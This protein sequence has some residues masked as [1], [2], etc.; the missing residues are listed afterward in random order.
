MSQGPRTIVDKVGWIVVALSAAY[1]VLTIGEPLRMNWGDPWTDCNALITGHFF[2]K[3]GFVKLAFTPI[4]DIEP[5]T[6]DSLRYTHYPPL[7]DIINGVQQRIHGAADLPVFRAPAIALSLYALLLFYRYV[8]LLWG[9]TE[10]TLTV[11]FFAGN[12]LWLQ[13]ADTI[14]HIPLYWAT[15]F[16]AML[17]SARWLRDHKTKDVVLAGVLTFAC[18]L[19]SYDFIFFVPVMIGATPLLLGQSLWTRETRRLFAA[20]AVGAAASIVLKYVL[21]IWAVGWPQ[22][23]GDLVFQF[24]ERATTKHGGDYKSGFSTILMF[25][26]WRFFTPIFFVVLALQVVLLAMRAFARPRAK[27]LAQAK[28]SASPLLLLVAGAPFI[29]VFSQLFCEQYHPTL[30]LLPYY[31]LSAAVLVTRCWESSRRELRAAAVGLLVLGFGWQV[32]ELAI[33]EKT[34]LLRSDIARVRSVLEEHDHHRFVLSNGVTIAPALYYWNRYQLGVSYMPPEAIPR[35]VV[36]LQDEFGDEPIR[37]LHF[38]DIEKSVIDKYLYGIFVGQR[39]WDWIAD[40]AGHVREWQPG[41][42]A[43]DEALVAYI[44]QF[45][46][47]EL[48]TGTMRVYRMDRKTIDDFLSKKIMATPTTSIDFGDKSSE[49]F[50]VYGVRYPEKYGEG[51]GFAWLQRR[52]PGRYKFTLQGL[53]SVP[54]GTPRDDAALRLAMPPGKSYRIEISAVTAVPDQILTATVNGSRE[55]ARAPIPMGDPSTVVIDV[56]A[57]LLEASGLQRLRLEM[58]KVNAEGLGVALRTLRITSN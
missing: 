36:D 39:K 15:G 4:I 6:R 11:A 46:A 54:M 17:C 19:S 29:A 28:W 26:L 7:P 3:Y 38:A 37:F 53:R 8:K 18:F 30:I 43:R 42:R 10:A 41:V 22:F 21:V 49:S 9:R 45:S 48:D 1:L 25:R 5:L 50:K 14:N 51:Q 56:P 33:F 34:F 47:L 55:L 44:A 23:Y 13:Y 57:E 2:D 20:V 12:L 40:P 27:E 16:G 52:Q 24:H 35:Y 58:S 31:A 32:K